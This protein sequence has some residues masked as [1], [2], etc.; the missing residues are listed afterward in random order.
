MAE[1]SG[2]RQVDQVDVRC[3]ETSRMADALKVRL[4]FDEEAGGVEA[5]NSGILM[6]TMT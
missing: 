2:T 1:E 5:P 4:Q 3:T 6:P